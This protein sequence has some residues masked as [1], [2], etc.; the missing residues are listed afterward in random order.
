MA[1]LHR[2]AARR[3]SLHVDVDVV[4]DGGMADVYGILYA[5]MEHNFDDQH[6][7]SSA[8][9]NGVPAPTPGSTPT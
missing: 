2:S 4:M 1:P 8:V 5:A 3:Q 6:R 7:P 9:R